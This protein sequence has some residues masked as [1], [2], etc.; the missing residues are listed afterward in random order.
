MTTVVLRRK[1]AEAVSLLRTGRELVRD[2]P[3]DVY[4]ANPHESMRGSIG[5]HFRHVLDYY[6]TFVR[7][8]ESG[9]LDYDTRRRDSLI[10]QD[11]SAAV[12][13]IERICAHLA[14]VKASMLRMPLAVRLAADGNSPGAWAATSVLRELEFLIG[15]TIHH[16]AIIALMCA[17]GGMAIPPGFGVAPSTLRYLENQ[18]AGPGQRPKC[19]ELEEI[20]Q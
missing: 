11:P 10:E 13:E 17:R 18:R 19:I 1:S 20:G 9:R 7:E 14:G 2:M 16:Y 12:A 15:H 8:L 3:L 5:I 6:G 4:R